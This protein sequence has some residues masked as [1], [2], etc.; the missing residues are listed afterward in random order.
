[1]AVV[2][3]LASIKK[4]QAEQQEKREAGGKKFP[5]YL[6]KVFPKVVGN[7]IVV[8]FLQELDPDMTNYR[9]DRGIGLIAVEHEAGAADKDSQAPKRGFMYRAVCSASDEGECY[10]CEKHKENYKGGWR[11][12]Q[13]LY[14]NVLAEVEGEKKVFVLSKNANSTFAQSLIQEAIDEGSITDANYRITK[15]GDG[16]QTQWL[17]KRLK[18]EPLDDSGVELWDI[19]NEV[20]KNVPYDE[21]AEFYGK[22]HEGFTPREDSSSQSR[23]SA[24]AADDNDEW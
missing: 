6:Y 20:L 12:K 21:Q 5:E 15:T 9:E 4:H 24:P 10:G 17:I 18:T 7:E 13:N 8:R 11:P 1:M 19:E 2:K 14:I 16:P 22:A 3:G 23:P